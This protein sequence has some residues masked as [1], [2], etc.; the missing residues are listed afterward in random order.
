MSCFSPTEQ[1]TTVSF[2]YCSLSYHMTLPCD[3]C[4]LLLASNNDSCLYSPN[5]VTKVHGHKNI[6]AKRGQTP[7]MT[8]EQVI[9]FYGSANS[10]FA[11]LEGY[12]HLSVLSPVLIVD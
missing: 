2:P 12:C 11:H 8:V 7:S 4:P 1:S 6:L 10:S 5:S 3:H 9:N